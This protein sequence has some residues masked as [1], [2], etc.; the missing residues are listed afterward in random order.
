MFVLGGVALLGLAVAWPSLPK[1][2]ASRVEV[3]EALTGVNTGQSYA[4]VLKTQY[5]AALV[6]AGGDVEGKALLKEL[7]V[8]GLSPEDVH[9]I[10]IT[11][12]HM[13]HWAAAHLF[14]NARVWVGP[15][16]AAILRGQFPLTSPVGRLTSLLPR[17][18]VPPHVESVR[19]GEELELDGEKVLAIHV[20][21]H[22]PGSTMY[23]WRDVLFTGDSL[24]RSNSGLAPAPFV[25]SESRSQ[26][27]SSLHKLLE[28][29]FTRTADGHSGVTDNARE[30][31]R[32]LLR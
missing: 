14:P 4:W 6:D 16:E 5:G 28:V 21:G 2:G 25:L 1:A 7:S 8:L 24:V 3:G 11:H 32:G 30:E 9:S 18:P 23:L 27:V 19:D 12:G 10:L 29:P 26:N 13:D 15:G 31:L 17:P 20:P 22:T